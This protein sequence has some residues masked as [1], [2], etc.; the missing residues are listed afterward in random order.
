[1]FYV[2]LD[3][4]FHHAALSQDEVDT[5]I[6]QM[7]EAWDTKANAPKPGTDRFFI[8]TTKDGTSPHNGFFVD[9]SNEADARTAAQR[10]IDGSETVLKAVGA[11]R[12]AYDPKRFQALPLDGQ[13]VLRNGVIIDVVPTPSEAKAAVEA[14]IARHVTEQTKHRNFDRAKL[15]GETDG[16]VVNR[17]LRPQFAIVEAVGGEFK[18]PSTT[19]GPKKR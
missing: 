11:P 19:A 9:A 15:P 17:I 16:D 8:T 12:N 18:K 2:R 13:V 14:R 3:G 4:K 1:M 7:T 5:F 6:A 10:L